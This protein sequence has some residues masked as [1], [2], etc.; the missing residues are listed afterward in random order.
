MEWDKEKILAFRKKKLGLTQYKFAEVMGTSQKI[1]SEWETG[2]QKPCGMSQ[3]FL[4]LLAS[5]DIKRNIREFLSLE[6]K[7]SG[8]SSE[9]IL[10]LREKLDFSQTEFAEKLGRNHSTIS[11]WESGKKSP[12]KESL[13]RIKKLAKEE[14][15]ELPQKA[16]AG[17]IPESK[18]TDN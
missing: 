16:Q 1:I 15:I 5:I 2:K 10:A 11:Y 4:T 7:E 18:K 6:Q 3:K 13:R 12:G 9:E 8:I 14:G 17:K